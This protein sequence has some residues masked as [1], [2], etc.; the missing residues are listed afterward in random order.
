MHQVLVSRDFQK[1]FHEL[2]ANLQKRA[3]RALKCLEEDPFQPRSGA[4]I[5]SLEGTNPQKYRIRIGDYR[6][7][8]VVD[9]PTVKVLEIFIRGRDYRP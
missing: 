8:Y 1:Q 7:V 3:R 6:L 9:G 2:S 4:D 5:K